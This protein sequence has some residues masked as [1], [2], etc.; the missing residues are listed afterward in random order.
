MLNRWPFLLAVEQAGDPC[1]MGTAMAIGLKSKFLAGQS[2]GGR[3]H[4]IGVLASGAFAQA[5]LRLGPGDKLKVTV[6]DEDDASGEYEIDATGSFPSGS[7][8]ASRSRK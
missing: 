6:F 7:S 4:D 2:S 8:A 1:A 3:G 5:G